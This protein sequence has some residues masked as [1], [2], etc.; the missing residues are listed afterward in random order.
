MSTKEITE[1]E[2][3]DSFRDSA[4]AICRDLGLSED[5]AELTV[6]DYLGYDEEI[7]Y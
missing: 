1:V 6:D 4:M 2:F 7:I 3:D 5:E